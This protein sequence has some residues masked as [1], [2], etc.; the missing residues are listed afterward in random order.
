MPGSAGDNIFES[1]HKYHFAKVPIS[2]IG[3][4]RLPVG[5]ETC[6]DIAFLGVLDIAERSIVIFALISGR[7][8]ETS[9]PPFSVSPSRAAV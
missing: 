8:V 7:V 2:N 3:H 9:A 6:F 5:F 1:G 4:H